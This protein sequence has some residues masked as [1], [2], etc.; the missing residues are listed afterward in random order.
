MNLPEL[1]D[2]GDQRVILVPPAEPA[3]FSLTKAVGR[4]DLDLAHVWYGILSSVI[5]FAKLRSEQQT[6]FLS[7]LCPPLTSHARRLLK[8]LRFGLFPEPNANRTKEG[9]KHG[10]RFY[11][12]NIPIEVSKYLFQDFNR[13]LG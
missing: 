8:I 10:H 3:H 1:W 4:G 9:G 2:D 7:F 5:R 6:P 12:G 13:T 11:L